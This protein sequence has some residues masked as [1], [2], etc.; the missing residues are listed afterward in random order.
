[1]AYSPSRGH[2]LA[3]GLLARGPERHGE[4]V[5]AADPLRGE[6]V[7]AEICPPCFVDPQGERLRV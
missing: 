6:E 3:L 7:L 4:I 1:M 2:W 5:L